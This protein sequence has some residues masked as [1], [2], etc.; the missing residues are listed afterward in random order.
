METQ[1]SLGLIPG[2]NSN[3][4]G[5]DRGKHKDPGLK[6]FNILFFILIKYSFEILGKFGW[7]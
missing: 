4:S 2:E 5:K 1:T 6:C 3:L 7:G